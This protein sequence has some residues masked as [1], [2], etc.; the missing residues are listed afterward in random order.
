MFLYVIRAIANFLL[1]LRLPGVQELID[2]CWSAQECQF[3]PTAGGYETDS[4]G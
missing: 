4:G 2:W 3:V 1:R